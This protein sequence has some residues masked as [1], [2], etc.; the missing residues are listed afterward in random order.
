MTDWIDINEVL[1]EMDKIA[2]DGRPVVFSLAWIRVTKGAGG[3]RGSICRVN[4]A[5]KYTKPY[6]RPKTMPQSTYKFIKYNAIPIRDLDINQL[7]TP[8][9]THIV[10]F[11]GKKVR[12]Y[13]SV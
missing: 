5:M 8:K 3:G 6:K 10:E 4:K 13:G 7:R 12:H 11:N 1:A 2:D 9:W